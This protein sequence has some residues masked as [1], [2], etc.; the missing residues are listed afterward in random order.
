[1][2]KIQFLNHKGELNIETNCVRFYE[3]VFNGIRDAEKFLTNV[4]TSGEYE[5]WVYKGEK[6]LR[7]CKTG[8]IYYDTRWLPDEEFARKLIDIFE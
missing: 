8:W 6:G 7:N 1:M 4:P 3:H 2:M 5:V